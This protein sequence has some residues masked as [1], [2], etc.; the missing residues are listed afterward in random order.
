MNSQNGKSP[1][2]SRLRRTA[3]MGASDDIRGSSYREN[4]SVICIWHFGCDQFR[5]TEDPMKKLTA[6][7]LTLLLAASAFAQVDD[8]E[9]AKKGAI[10]GGVAGAIAGTIIGNNPGHHSG[11]PGAVA[12]PAAGT[13]AGAIVGAMMDRQGSATRQLQG[14]R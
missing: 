11:K 2:S 1:L 12:D 7:L 14:A 8:H 9:K 10:I 3:S 5:Q 4:L 6:T 13:A